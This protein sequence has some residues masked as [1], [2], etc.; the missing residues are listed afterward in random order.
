MTEEEW[1]AVAVAGTVLLGCIVGLI[2]Y[3]GV[4]CVRMRSLTSEVD[5][6][7]RQ[8]Q[9][10][11]YS[12]VRE[13]LQLLAENDADRF[14]GLLPVDV[15]VPLP[16]SVCAALKAD[17]VI[18]QAM[19]R[20]SS[21][22]FAASGGGFGGGAA[23]P[24][25]A[26]ASRGAARAALLGDAAST[27]APSLA[28]AIEATLQPV[29]G[30]G[31]S[32]S[33]L[34]LAIPAAAESSGA[35]EKF[36]TQYVVPPDSFAAFVAALGDVAELN[37]T[38]ARSDIAWVRVL[39]FDEPWRGQRRVKLWRAL[40]SAGGAAGAGAAAA[41]AMATAPRRDD[42]ARVPP[43]HEALREPLMAL[44]ERDD[45]V[46]DL[47]AAEEEEERC[48]SSKL[49]TL[50]VVRN[51]S[52]AL[53]GTRG[54][55]RGQERLERLL[56]R[57][58]TGESVRTMRLMYKQGLESLAAPLLWICT[59]TRGDDLTDASSDGLAPLV[60]AAAAATAAA[61]AEPADEVACELLNGIVS[62]FVSGYYQIGALGSRH[63]R[64]Q[65]EVAGGLLCWWD[66]LLGSFLSQKGLHPVLYMIPWLET[67]FAAIL[68]LPALVRAWDTIFGCDRAIVPMVAVAIMGELRE[69]L[70]QCNDMGACLKLFSAIN[71]GATTVVVEEAASPNVR[72]ERP[73]SGGLELVI[74][75]SSTAD[76][77]SNAQGEE[78]QQQ[79][80]MFDMR[81]CL[82]AA[83][84]M[85]R[86][87]PPSLYRSMMID[88]AG[89]ATA[90]GGG[91]RSTASGGAL[92]RRRASS[93]STGFGDTM[94]LY[95]I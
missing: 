63:L 9:A 54:V 84:R 87:T 29:R 65:L 37:V 76:L 64:A 91:S 81:A 41:A 88:G 30:A 42:G 35:R 48:R 71:S 90:A 10:T 15:V 18:E 56:H 44:A 40:L 14:E 46:V 69:H 6:Y 92:G 50:D 8:L 21:G 78:H 11:G 57:W 43:P 55:A 85:Y 73:S 89:G 83:M 12:S 27:L 13:P 5:R 77:A 45:D 34:S 26:A 80:L 39:G 28:P 53:D 2:G 7:M 52:E 19:L 20:S 74:G 68:P 33:N 59:E 82:S 4:E 49:I 22:L 60:D 75:G 31:S 38:A 86:L 66:P 47:E 24:A 16:R 70:I 58:V 3:L 72:S 61:A 79:P 62:K 32:S 36:T 17:G 23:S 95:V 94:L 1:I 93:T 25:S 67:L 51:T